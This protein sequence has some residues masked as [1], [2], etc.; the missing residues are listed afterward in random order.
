MTSRLEPASIASFIDQTLLGPSVTRQQAR[1]WV[2]LSVLHPFASL[3]VSPWLVPQTV[4]IA[5]ERGIPVCTVIGF[6]HGIH[7]GSVKA[8]EAA[9]ALDAGAI[10][11]DM[12]MNV[13]AFLSGDEGV[14]ADEIAAVASEIG[15]AA[16]PGS[17]LKVILCSAFLS[18]EQLT[19]ACRLV[20]D[21]GA[22]FVKTSTGYEHQGASEAHIRLMR[23][24]VGPD[25]GVKA[26]G[27]IRDS[28][29]ARAMI[30]AGANRIGTSRGIEIAAAEDR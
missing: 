15:R 26:S 29:S 30:D 4:E 22:D 20:V 2:E 19:A 6:P 11:I 23:A 21:A 17:L 10:E 28:E 13:G 27:G 24:T 25:F 12:V 1:E 3:C 16:V 9:Q 5:L 8:Y 14:V 7:A 18:D